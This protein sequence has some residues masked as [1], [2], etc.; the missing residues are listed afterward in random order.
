MGHLERKILEWYIANYPQ[1]SD[2]LKSFINSCRVTEREFTSGA[3]V[4]VSLA[5]K[6]TVN[7]D[8][9]EDVAQIDGPFIKSPELELEACVGLGVDAQN[10]IEYI[11]IWAP[12][13]DYPH[14]Q[15]VKDFEFIQPQMNY[16]DLR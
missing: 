12:S 2:E 4:F 10:N 3:G 6:V 8:L 13:G 11:E 1:Y 5:S 7:L 9:D 15:H 16:V 14:N